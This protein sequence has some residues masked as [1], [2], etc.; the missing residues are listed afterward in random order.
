MF[1]NL[2]K[3]IDIKMTQLISE[4]RK[5]KKKSLI[6]SANGLFRFPMETSKQRQFG[7]IDRDK[8]SIKLGNFAPANLKNSLKGNNTLK[9]LEIFD[10]YLHHIIIF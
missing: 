1:V 7:N 6:G 8:A 2:K 5:N 3:F 10:E 9:W 4:N